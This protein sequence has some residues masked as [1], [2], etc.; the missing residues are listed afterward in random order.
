MNVWSAQSRLQRDS[1]QAFTLVELLV[2]IAII[3]L[4]SSATLF[5]LYGVREDAREDRARSQVMRIHQLLVQHWEGYRTRPIPV[6]VSTSGQSPMNAAGARLS[7][8]RELMRMELPDRK[9]DLLFPINEYP[10]NPADQTRFLKSR[11]SLWRT[12]VRRA[13]Q[14]I[15]G[16][17]PAAPDPTNAWK[18]DAFWT[19]QH[20]HA[21]CL[22]LILASIRD[23]N[24]TGLDA[25]TEGEIDDV[26]NDGMP[27]IVDPWGVPVYFLRWA[28]GFLSDLQPGDLEPTTD[29]DAGTGNGDAFDYLKIDPRWTDGVAYN[30]PCLLYP[31]VIC[32]GRDKQF[33]I[34]TDFL[35]VP[36][37]QPIVSVLNH[38]PSTPPSTTTSPPHQNL[39][40]DPYVTFDHPTLVDPIWGSIVRIGR[41]ADTNG[42]GIIGHADNIT[43][44]FM[45]VR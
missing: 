34:M 32:A 26:D 28:P 44:H 10:T 12:Y 20:Q 33:D 23:G 4:I 25:F 24:S 19:P 43:N 21:E 16:R 3:T 45:Q 6:K 30:D 14:Q 22:Y 13:R 7:A 38:N 11:P 5:T 27:E 8:L 42:D 40:N 29:A 31:L 17:Y 37:P 9:T 41:P 2:V 1:R 39:Y 15:I 35:A 36:F 18:D